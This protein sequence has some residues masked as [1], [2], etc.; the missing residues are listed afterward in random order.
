MKP[1]RSFGWRLVYFIQRSI[2]LIGPPLHS[3]HWK[4]F[5]AMLLGLFVPA[6]YF[7]WQ[8]RV[9]IERSHLRSTEQGMID[10]ALVLADTLGEH[11]SLTRLPMAHEIK[12][13]VFKDLSPD[14]RIVVYDAEGRVVSD[15]AGLWKPGTP[16]AGHKD[17][18]EALQGKH[19]ARWA[20]DPRR[21][22]GDPT[23]P[24]VTLYSTIPVFHDGQVTGA[25]GI[26]KTTFDVRRSIL[27][28]LK[29]LALPA[30]VA[31]V[32]AAGT[33]YLLSSYL[34]RV[35][36]GLAARAE[37]IAA[38]EPGVRLET[39]TK[40][41]LGDLA[42]AL[43]TMRRKLEGR[44]YV[45]EMASTLSHELKTPLAAI[46]GAAEIL[47]TNDSPAARNKFLGNIRAEVDRLTGIVN[48]LLALSRIETRPPEG[49]SCRVSEVAAGVAGA[50]Q[51]RAET[52]GL[53]FANSCEDSGESVP[54]SADDLRR[55]MEILLDNAFAFTP[56]GRKVHLATTGKSIVV[57][58]QGS[59]IDPELQTK[60]FERFFTTTNPLTG[61]RGSGLGLAIARSIVTHADGRIDLQSRPGEGT[62]VTV[63]FP[64]ASSEES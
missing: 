59:G 29:D 5:A 14:L 30:L 12:R 27:R 60:V 17:V 54:L 50:F 58:D 3:L 41:E 33:S 10:T 13:R 48:D 20:R 23:R 25:V 19:G 37:R 42:R 22:R 51:S 18:R 52:L 21:W 34:T 62:T 24:I 56:A 36:T 38:G 53:Q 28:S 6:V 4:I 16:N 46:R 9:T 44:A 47:E 31:F 15:T 45:E 7:L 35:I 43:E 32:L 49:A 63:R 40:S 55:V 64:E 2:T 26:I 61:R 8:V 39:W 11:S 57:R 1:A